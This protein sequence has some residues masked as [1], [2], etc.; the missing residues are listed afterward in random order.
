VVVVVRGMN[1]AAAAQSSRT[2]A[3]VRENRTA[4][5]S[6]MNAPV[7]GCRTAGPHTEGTQNI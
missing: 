2:Q 3:A 5:D 6:Y 1:S 7:W 4:S